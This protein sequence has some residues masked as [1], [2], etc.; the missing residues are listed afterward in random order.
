MGLSHC[1]NECFSLHNAA[2]IFYNICDFLQMDDIP[3]DVWSSAASYNQPDLTE[4]VLNES[5]SGTRCSVIQF[6]N[7]QYA[8][9]LSSS[10]GSGWSS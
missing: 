9:V 2:F 7:V 6:Y 10:Q 4:L 1:D 3:Y 8:A 5:T